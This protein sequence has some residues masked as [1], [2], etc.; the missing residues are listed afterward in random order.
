M[1]T[2]NNTGLKTS[3]VSKPFIMLASAYKRLDKAVGHI[4]RPHEVIILG[5]VLLAAY[6][7]HTCS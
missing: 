4:A 2:E 7:A 3:V 6:K 1:T 5:L